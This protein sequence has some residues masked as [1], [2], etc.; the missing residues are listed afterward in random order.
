VLPSLSVAPDT[1]A[2]NDTMLGIVGD[3]SVPS[4]YTVAASAG[5]PLAIELGP[6]QLMRIA[7]G[8][9]KNNDPTVL[10]LS[11]AVPSSKINSLP[12]KFL[13]RAGRKLRLIVADDYVA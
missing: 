10:S 6:P 9:N 11:M 7:S 5:V 8:S 1:V 13:L 2:T 4:V 3:A 12:D